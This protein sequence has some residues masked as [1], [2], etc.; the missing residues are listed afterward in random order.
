MNQVG[1]D[2]GG[3]FTDVL[4]YDPAQHQ[5]RIG[6]VL[7]TPEDPAL[8]VL[9]GL[10]QVM[11]GPESAASLSRI[12]HGTT[13]VTNALI[14]RKGALTAL[15][16]TQGFRDAVEI[17]REHRYDL[18]D[19]FIERP[20]SLAPRWLRREVPERLRADGTILIPLDVSETRRI[21]RDLRGLGVEAIAVSFLHAYRND[22]H[23]RRAA[24]IIADE[25]PEIIVSLSSDIHPHL[26]EYERTSTTLANVYVRRLVQAYLEQLE[27]QLAALGFTGSLFAM[28]SSGGICSVETAQRYP[29]RLV[30]SGPAA[31]A[32]AAAEFGRHLGESHLLAF[33]MGGT[34]AKAALI[35]DGRPLRSQQFEVCRVYRFKRGSGLPISV[36]A[37]ELIEI[38]AGGGSIARVDAMGLLKVGPDSAGA[39]PGPACYGRGG[40]LPTVTDADLVLGYLDADFFLGGA[41]PLDRSA[42]E[43]A[44]QAHLARPLGLDLQRAAW[45]VHQVVNENMAGAARMHAIEH[46]EDPRAYTLFAFGGAG[47]GHAYRVA[48][49]LGISR[50]IVPFGAGVASTIG[51]LAAPLAFDFVRSDYAPLDEVDWS[52]VRCH[53]TEME[54]EG[55]ALVTRAGVD[56]E[57]VA[58]RRTVEMR[59][60]GQGHE[61][62]VDVPPGEPSSAM[63]DALVQNFEAAYRTLYGRT[64]PGVPIEILT[65]RLDVSGPRPGLPLAAF[66]AQPPSPPASQRGEGKSEQAIK[67]ERPMYLPEYQ[68]YR[69]VP[70]YDRYALRPG[71]IFAGPAIIEERESTVIVGPRGNVEV[72]QYRNLMITLTS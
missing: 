50:I 45:G 1:V 64:A 47:P 27:A 8:G 31:G 61:V 66:S 72:D 10:R 60:T 34:T 56:A 43:R 23:E 62:T 69:S 36:P 53:L 54:A 3:T 19:I 55:R 35:K 46:G 20:T 33:D 7:T 4:L 40:T 28:L 65:W 68:A 13:L 52:R 49:I 42:A 63:C 67:G 51:F 14:E 2:I 29:I 44:L 38:G 59:Y 58:V 32:L 6:K 25:A 37:I 24:A 30:E 26:G 11:P 57:Q 9:D 39:A 12:V 71:H 5:F 70:V 48:D 41:M 17:G 21:V 22:R 16:T 15:L 18:Y